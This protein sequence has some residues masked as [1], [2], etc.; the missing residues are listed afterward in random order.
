MAAPRRLVGWLG[1][2]R[3]TPGRQSLGGMAVVAMRC[4]ADESNRSSM[5]IDAGA[6]ARDLAGQASHGMLH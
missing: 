3:V 5:P 4:V 2:R 6:L 1:R